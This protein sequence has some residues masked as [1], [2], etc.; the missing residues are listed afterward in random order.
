MKKSKSEK[1][2]DK[3][4]SQTYDQLERVIDKV[5]DTHITQNNIILNCYGNETVEHI[6]DKQKLELLTLPY[7]M[8]LLIKD[9]ILILYVPK[10]IIFITQKGTICKNIFRR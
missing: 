3:I 7:S 4:I 2:K 5:G 9:V 1:N 6:S 8:T 10:I